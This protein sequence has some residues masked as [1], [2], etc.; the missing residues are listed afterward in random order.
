MT[1]VSDPVTGL[2][3]GLPE[4]W[5]SRVPSGVDLILVNDDPSRPSTVFAPNAVA[6]VVPVK[7]DVTVID[8]LEQSTRGWIDAFPGGQVTA[9]DFAVLG[10]LDARRVISSYSDETVGVTV[11]SYLCVANSLATRI[12]VSVG[13]WDTSAGTAAAAEIVAGFVPPTRFAEDSDVE[14]GQRAGI[15]DFVKGLISRDR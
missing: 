4:N 9:V 15:V 10:G 12:D 1:T 7:D 11:I 2:A 6:A 8:F 14:S 3:L 5:N 13:V